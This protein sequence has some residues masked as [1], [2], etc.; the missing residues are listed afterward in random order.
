M[1]A[2]NTF[3]YKNLEFSNV[4]SMWSKQKPSYK[5]FSE[6]E[7]S[8]TVFIWIRTY[9]IKDLV[10]KKHSMPALILGFIQ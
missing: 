9:V 2:L 5:Q 1:A 6:F 10:N 4:K 7:Q 8:K 3:F